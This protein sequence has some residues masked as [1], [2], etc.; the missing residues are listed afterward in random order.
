MIH[1]VEILCTKLL[2]F[3]KGSVTPVRTI[4]FV[5]VVMR[6]AVWRPHNGEQSTN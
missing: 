5:L 4:H 1:I 2:Q 6:D 3:E